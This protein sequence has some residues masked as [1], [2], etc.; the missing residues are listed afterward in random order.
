MWRLLYEGPSNPAVKLRRV[1]LDFYPAMIVFLALFPAIALDAIKFTH[2]LVGP[3]VRFRQTIRDVAEGKPVQPIRLR[4]DDMLTEMRDEFNAMLES[5]Q[6][7]GV[8]VLKPL[9]PS[10]ERP[11][12]SRTA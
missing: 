5:L 6:K 10:E 2:K 3:L 4:K 12:K 9:S 11:G 8:P 1:L 7:R